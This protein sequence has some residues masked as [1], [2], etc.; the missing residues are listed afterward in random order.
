[1]ADSFVMMSVGPFR[2]SINTAAYD[3]LERSS[4]WRVASIDRLGARPAL[5]SNDR[6]AA[7][8]AGALLT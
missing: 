2:F 1:M 7:F 8:A 3:E 6:Y 4:S 5:A